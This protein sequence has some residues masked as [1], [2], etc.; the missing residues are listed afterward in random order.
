M[1]IASGVSAVV[2]LTSNYARQ[3]GSVQSL[4]QERARAGEIYARGNNLTAAVGQSP[5]CQVFNPAASGKTVIVLEF[6]IGCSVTGRVFWGF[7]VGALTSLH[8]TL[9][10]VNKGGAAA[11]A[12]L[13][14][15]SAAALLIGNILGQTA[16]LA[17]TPLHVEGPWILDPNEG[18]VVINNSS[19]S[20]LDFGFTIWEF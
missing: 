3:F 11:T 18:F 7:D 10:N 14:S 20:I 15:Q 1:R 5:Q 8:G 16:L 13:R 9:F 12:E 2:E 19:N 17:N 4:K 6:F